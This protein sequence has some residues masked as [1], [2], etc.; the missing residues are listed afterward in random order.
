[1]STHEVSTDERLTN[2]SELT[3]LATD[4]HY[5]RRGAGTLLVQW[6]LDKCKAEHYPAYLE[7][8]PE[9]SGLYKRLG[10]VFQKRLSVTHEDGSIYEE[11]AYLFR[12]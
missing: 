8:T 2:P 7:A 6:G 5:E 9:G 3:L 11:E 4:P 10:F 12:P 1:M